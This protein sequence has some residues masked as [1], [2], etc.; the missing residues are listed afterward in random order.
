MAV[1]LAE[2]HDG[3]TNP[4]R[5]LFEKMSIWCCLVPTWACL[6]LP[7]WGCMGPIWCQ[8]GPVWCY[9]GLS[10][11]VCGQSDA[12][13]RLVWCYIGLSGGV[14][15]QSNANLGLSG[16]TWASLGLPGA[17]MVPI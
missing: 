1:A 14:W 7:L 3:S 9:L 4:V 17:N 12:N 11:V 16:A 8:S 6:V 13:L 10:G 15:G 2:V 5:K